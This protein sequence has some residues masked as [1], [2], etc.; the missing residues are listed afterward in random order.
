MEK[1]AVCGFGYDCVFSVNVSC[2][3]ILQKLK[4]DKVS[5]HYLKHINIKST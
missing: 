3:S 2:V 4:R 1:L 5:Q